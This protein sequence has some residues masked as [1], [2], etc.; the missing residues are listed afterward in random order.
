M[1]NILYGTMDFAR[2]PIL[3]LLKH[4]IEKRLDETWGKGRLQKYLFTKSVDSFYLQTLL[5]YKW[6][7]STKRNLDS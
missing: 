1:T 4:I 2:Q 5:I 7:F 3:P 6:V